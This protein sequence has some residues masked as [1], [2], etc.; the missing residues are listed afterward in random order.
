MIRSFLV[1]LILLI[2][3]GVDSMATTIPQEVKSTVTFIFIKNNAG[4]LTPNGTGFFA[5]LKNEHDPN[6]LNVY[7]ITARHVLLNKKTGSLV[8]SVY[9]RLNKKTGDSQICEIV[10]CGSNAIKVFN[11]KD[12]NVDISVIPMVPDPNVFDFKCIPE[13]MITTK[14][15]F[16]ELKITEGDEVFFVGLFTPY[17]GKQK[18][19]PIVRFGRVALITNEKIPWPEKK[20]ESPKMLDLYLLETQSFG[21]NSGS[22]VFFYLGATREPGSIVIGPPKLLLA[23]VMKGSFLDAKKIQ[24]IETSKIP[25]SL[26][27]IGIA[28][29]VP[30]YKL[31]EILFSNELKE[32][33]STVKKQT[34]QEKKGN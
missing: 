4:Q 33:R 11:H 34:V 13:N 22:P 7:L 27:N 8:N 21:G 20:D 16:T 2:T 6:L 14:E 32:S 25:V 23:G 24:V 17:F 29:V 30:A 9:I 19:Y 15:K 31:H 26:E 18:N 12:T 5:S 3:S 28:G 1:I 10:L